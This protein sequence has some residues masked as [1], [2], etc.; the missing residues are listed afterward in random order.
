[1]SFQEQQITFDNRNHQLTNINVWTPDSQWL[2]YDVR[3][4]GSSFTGITI[5]KIHVK[6]KQHQV[7]Y[8]ATEGAHVGV[9]TVSPL[10]PVRYVFIH[11]PENPDNEWQ[12]DFHHRRGVI[13]DESKLDVIQNLDACCLTAPYQAGALR[14]GTHVHVFNP[15]SSRLSFTYND[16]V[17]HE[18]GAEHDQRNVA[19]AVP[20]KPVQ[21]IKK[22]PREYD[23]DYFC[24]VISKTV[25]HPKKGSDEISRAY[26]ECWIGTKGYINTKGYRQYSAIAFIGDTISIKGEKVPDI[27]LVDLPDDDS[28]LTI[29]G[30]MPLAGTEFTLPAP[31]KG[32]HQVRLTNT[33]KRKYPGI[34]TEPRHWLR[35]SPNGEAIAFLMKDDNGIVQLYTVSPRTKKIKQITMQDWGIQS[36][37]T[38]SADGQYLTFICDNSVMLCHANTGELTRLTQKTQLAPSGDAVVFSPDNKSIA[39]MRD[40]EGYRQL[41]IVET[42]L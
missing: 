19:I 15:D 21:V 24:T 22:H 25:A 7:I 2:V 28:A 26:E 27:F 31:A 17:M 11:G 41:F 14:G 37:F 16:H 6:T 20:L 29:E 30:D 12:Y 3:P 42:R 40:I 36:A 5:E 1:M 23:G 10:E 18:L 9:V 32:I 34:A 39:F 8:T 13:I 4:S 35:S 38:W 33:T